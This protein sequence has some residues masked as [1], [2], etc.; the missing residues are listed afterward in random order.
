MKIL[1]ACER[2][3]RIR[4]ALIALGHEAWSCD[5]KPT[6]VPGPHLQ[7]DVRDV[8]YDAWDG[9]IAHPVCK[10]LTNA[11]AKHLYR[12]IDGIWAKEHG[13][14]PER[15][16]LMREGAN[17]F[18]IF[19]DATHIPLRGIENP[20]MHG[21]ARK[22]I[23]LD[24]QRVKPQ[25]VQPW[26]FGDAFSKATGWWLYGLPKLRPEYARSW[27]SDR[28]IEIKQACWLMPPS[29][30]REEKRSETYPGMARAVAEQWFGVADQ[31]R[32]DLETRFGRS[33]YLENR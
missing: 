6:R 19:R 1:V 8:L 13:P 28:G 24:G 12:R 22:L 9:L 33:E 15:W 21:H 2:S 10:Y 3:G 30:D 25:Y 18:N 31:A 5:T 26:W 29:D 27:Y 32:P 14:D 20:I 4:D 23:E 17:F 16:R 11:G 7:C